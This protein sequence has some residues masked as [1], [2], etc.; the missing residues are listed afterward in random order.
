MELKG[1]IIA[2]GNTTASPA[3]V[4]AVKFTVGNA[5]SG[6]AIDLTAPP[7]NKTVLA[8]IDENVYENNMTWACSFIGSNDGDDLLEIGEKA[9]IT[10]D[11]SALATKHHKVY[12]RK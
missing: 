11:L 3:Y 2:T 10:V 1:S 12:E 4:T 7:S 8:Y 9:E 5:V 6:E